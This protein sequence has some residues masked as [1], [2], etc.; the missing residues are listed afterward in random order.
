MSEERTIY[1]NNFRFTVS[2][3]D[4]YIEFSQIVPNYAIEGENENEI[5]TETT[6]RI[7]LIMPHGLAKELSEKIQLLSGDS[8]KKTDE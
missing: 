6:E 7:R 1:V 5:H 3:M 4:L 2:G 8:E